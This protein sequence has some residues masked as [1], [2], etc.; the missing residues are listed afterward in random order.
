MAEKVRSF[1][2]VASAADLPTGGKAE[3]DR[4]V[5]PGGGS[6]TDTA[7]EDESPVTVVKTF[8]SEPVENASATSA[9]QAS[10]SAN[11]S[12][13]ENGGG[14]SQ[15]QKAPAESVSVLTKPFSLK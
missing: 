8:P 2:G 15:D 14:D 3:S 6:E 1:I 13:N 5:A 10:T 12:A 11:A 7:D 4:Q 9:S